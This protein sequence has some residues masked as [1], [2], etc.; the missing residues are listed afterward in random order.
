M[1]M[2]QKKFIN[3]LQINSKFKIKTKSNYYNQENQMSKND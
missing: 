2:K 3:Y 1:Q